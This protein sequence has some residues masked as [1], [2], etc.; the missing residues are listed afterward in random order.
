MDIKAFKESLGQAEPP[1]G[2]SPP[3]RALWHQAR[4]SWEKAHELVQDEKTEAGAWVHAFLHRVAGD[5]SN[6]NYWYAIA[7][8]QQCS[9]TLS[10]E[11]QD[12]TDQLLAA[13]ALSELEMDH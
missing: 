1:A 12:I 9:S 10:A 2:L 4:G 13:Q 6:A 11:W 3:L 8:R 5:T 7:G